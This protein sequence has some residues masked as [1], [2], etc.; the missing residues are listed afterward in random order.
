MTSISDTLRVS[1][2]QIDVP[3]CWLPLLRLSVILI[4][5]LLDVMFVLGIPYF[6]T[7]LTTLC[8]LP[9][10]MP[11]VLTDTDVIMLEAAGLLPI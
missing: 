9:S 3:V 5:L 10:C 2:S 6:Y 7:H 4:L 11:L 8:T 1:K